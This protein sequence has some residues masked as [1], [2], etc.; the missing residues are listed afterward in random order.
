VTRISR[1]GNIGR[2]REEAT[3]KRLVATPVTTEHIDSMKLCYLFPVMRWRVGQ[4]IREWYRRI[5][6][7]L[8]DN[9][10][11]RDTSFLYYSIIVD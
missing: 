11:K 3:E 1:C 5:S 10:E 6:A 2:Y 8:A 7:I 9:R 4:V